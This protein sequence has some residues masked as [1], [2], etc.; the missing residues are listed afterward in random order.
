METTPRVGLMGLPLLAEVLRQS[1][2]D[3]VTG[4]S[5]RSAG[6]AIRQSITEHGPLPLLVE[7]TKTPGLTAFL[8]QHAS[9]APVV[10]VRIENGDGMDVAGAVSADPPI[11]VPELLALTGSPVPPALASSVL[12]ESGT[13]SGTPAAAAVEV[14]PDSPWDDEPQPA[15]VA[16][17]PQPMDPEPAATPWDDPVAPAHAPTPPSVPTAAPPVDPQPTPA[18]TPAPEATPWDEPATPAPT[19]PPPSVPIAAPPVAAPVEPPTPT[20]APTP[21]ATPWDDS[22]EPPP[23]PAPQPRE[24][25]P[26]PLAPDTWVS[27]APPV[28]QSEPIVEHR[29]APPA[30]YS[31]PPA[32]PIPTPPPVADYDPW[33]DTPQTPS[34]Q[35]QPAYRPRSSSNLAPVVFVLSGKG[36]TGKSSTA[37]L[38]AQRA[39]IHGHLNVALIDANRGQG[40]VTTYLRLDRASLRTMY[41]SAVTGDPLAGLVTAEELNAA[42][43][44]SLE[45]LGFAVC[46][47]PPAGMADPAVVTDAV[48]ART[49]DEVRRRADLV[50]VDTQIVESHDTSGLIDNFVAPTLAAG[51]WA[52]AASDTS[53]PSVNN[54]NFRL[55]AFQSLGIPPDRLLLLFN[56][57]DAAS[58]VQPEALND[59]FSTS[60]TTIG[61][62]VSDATLADAMNMGR[63]PHS[64]RAVVRHLDDVLYRVTGQGVFDPSNHDTKRTGGLLDTI[65]SKLGRN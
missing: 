43:H 63:L 30:P 56:R 19:P 29:P 32:Q 11:P 17:I 28:Q 36:G 18:P 49:L 5:L 12:D 58:S 10:L 25:A 20:P 26:P 16:P 42:R 48:Y 64:H 54:M 15:P 13:V 6:N 45:H 46:L 22:P 9:Q 33:S 21:A 1:G 35:A 7:D 31:Q 4:D 24:A 47:A 65:K 2:F 50:V 60:A 3:V 44:S 61:A 62:I 39:G 34:S 8:A 52:V 14:E 53:R 55:S 23:T 51:G 27:A 37:I 40:D 59:L 38:L 57:V 41:D